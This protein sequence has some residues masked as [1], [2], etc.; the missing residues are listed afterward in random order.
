MFFLSCI[1]KHTHVYIQYRNIAI[2]PI[3]PHFLSSH[4]FLRPTT[5]NSMVLALLTLRTLR[6]QGAGETPG[7]LCQRQ[8]WSPEA[9]T[10]SRQTQGDISLYAKV[11]DARHRP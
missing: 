3:N 10:E 11:A 9:S 1:Y 2:I 4:P 6:S 5:Q 8:Q 7:S